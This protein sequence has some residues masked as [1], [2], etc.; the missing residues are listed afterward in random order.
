MTKILFNSMDYVGEFGWDY[1][2]YEEGSMYFNDFLQKLIEQYENQY[3]TDVLSL[4]IVGRVGL[5]NGNPVGGK[6]IDRSENP[7]NH[8]GSVDHIDVEVEEDG[9]IT[10]NGHHHDGT[11]RMNLYLL[12]R[13]KLRKTAPYYLDY[14]ENH[15]EEIETIYEK[16]KPLKAKASLVNGFYG[17]RNA[18]EV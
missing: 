2:A 18:V 9:T 12:T 16:L 6:I 11:H 4:G 17:V 13:N 1:L 8:M 3:K 5:W 10:I 15:Y 14:R 7:L